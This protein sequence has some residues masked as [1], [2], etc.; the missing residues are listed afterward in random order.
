ME[1]SLI[2]FG[3][4]SIMRIKQAGQQALE[5]SAR[6]QEAIFPD[7]IAIDITR[8][9]IV[10]SV[11]TLPKYQHYVEGIGD[12]VTTWSQ[13]HDNTSSVDL[14]YLL[15]VKIKSE[16]G[17]DLDRWLTRNET[18]AG[19]TFIKQWSESS[20]PASPLA[21]IILTAADIALEYVSTNPKVIGVGSE[22]EKQ[23]AAFAEN[24]SELIDDQG[25]FGTKEGLA[26]RLGSAF[27]RSG[28]EAIAENPQWISSKKH[29]Q[30]FIANTS[31][32]VL[33]ALPTSLAEQLNYQQVVD[34][35]A[36]PV[37]NAALNTIVQNQQAF[38][39]DDFATSKAT[40]A[41]TQAVLVTAATGDLRE[42][43]SEEGLIE[44]YQSVLG[45][46]IN[47][48]ELFI[49][50]DGTA[51]SQLINNLFVGISTELQ[52]YPDLSKGDLGVKIATVVL[53]SV[54]RNIT[55]FI[56]QDT[57]WEKTLTEMIT[58]IGSNLSTALEEN[59]SL[60]NLFSNDY[61]IEITR[62]ILRNIAATPSMIIGN[63]ENLSA[64]MSAVAIAME[65]DKH[66]LLNGDDW[67]KIVDIISYEA[68]TNPARLFKLNTDDPSSMAGLQLIT[69]LVD[70]ANLAVSDPGNLATV[71]YGDTLSEAINIAIQLASRHTQTILGQLTPLKEA[72]QA[73]N[74]LVSS[75]P[76]QLGSQ[77]WLML[78][79]IILTRVSN[80]DDEIIFTIEQA[81]LIL[82]GEQQ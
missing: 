61:L 1:P 46:A 16:E 22:G 14:L 11:F 45:V 49:E 81:I 64:V 73:L 51:K 57:P 10:N 7:L 56:D 72:L 79:E 47:Q 41:I 2:L 75:H 29:M 3:I 54:N 58:L 26:E 20:E 55:N 25:N 19:I 53:G 27:L 4:K 5:Q 62:V 60:K 80:A 34:S 68:A 43:F 30:L 28:L 44:I 82:K 21:R 24:L 31:K 18:A 37:T 78:F 40:G 66:L 15:A 42:R 6:D 65:K 69:L 71:L 36:G 33:E 52:K 23:L 39:G 74:L 50:N 70:S 13:R 17:I 63:N 32:P 8:L 77:E 35:L 76:Q 9:D 12:Y 59:G 67:I 48:P 38:L